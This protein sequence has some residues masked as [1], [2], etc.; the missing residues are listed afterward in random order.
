MTRILFVIDG[1]E[2]GGGERGFLQIVRS[3]A[4]D[5]WA[6]AMAGQPGGLLEAG[7]VAAGAA[8]FPVAMSSRLAL[9]AVAR[10][11]RIVRQEGARLVH[12]Q[13]ARADFFTRLALAGLAGVRHVCT[14]QMP[15]EGFDVGPVLRACYVALDRLSARRVD[16]FI[17]VSRALERR[18]VERRGV[19]P[20][21]VTLIPNGVEL[22]CDDS[23]E[24]RE[25]ASRALRAE[26]GLGGDARLVGAAGRLVWQ[27][28]FEHLVRALPA[29][30]AREP[31][32]RLVI[33]G[34]GPLRPR[35]L[36]VARECGVEDRVLLPGFRRDVQDFLRALDVLVLPSLREGLPMVTL[37]AMAAGTPVVATAIEGVVEQVRHEADG[38][39]VPPGDP[40]A[41]AAAVT[42]LLADAALGARLARAARETVAARFDVRRTVAATRRVYA[43]LLGPAEGAR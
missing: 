4:A 28:G 8:F 16:R 1:L 19:A 2:F 34:E 41:L 24:R 35:L 29:V 32:A 18:L 10:L 20:A 38:L 39:L 11:R 26:L 12:S 27:K 15:V 30:L 37:E 22:P 13:G 23:P 42:R 43:E 25:R 33:A 17:V 14:V 5:G 21:R 7:A 40:G 9:G 31:R 3:L 36:A 6:V